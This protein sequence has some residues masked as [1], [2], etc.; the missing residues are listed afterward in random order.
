MIKL[1]T[2]VANFP[3]GYLCQA[4]FQTKF[5]VLLTSG[6]I[7]KQIFRRLVC[8]KLD[9]SLF[10]V[11]TLFSEQRARL[12]KFLF[13]VD[14]RNTGLRKRKHAAKKK[15]IGSVKTVCHLCQLLIMAK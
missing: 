2:Y 8:G 9:Q 1:R 14:I 11:S 15:S 13:L 7:L 4:N 10:V 5:P 6:N 3:M 12:L